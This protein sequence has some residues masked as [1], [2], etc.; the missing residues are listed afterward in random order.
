MSWSDVLDPSPAHPGANDEWHRF[1]HNIAGEGTAARRAWRGR[2][3]RRAAVLDILCASVAGVIGYF[4]WFVWSGLESAPRPPFWFVGLL[5]L[6]WAPAMVVARTYEERFLWVGVE[7]YRRVLSAAVVLLAGVGTVAWA[8]R[9][10]LARGLVVVTLPLTTLLTLL[11]RFAHRHWLSRQR[12]R[13]HYQQTTILV[14]H[15]AAVRALDEQLQREAHQG[16]RVIGCCL[17]RGEHSREADAFDRLPILGALDEVADVVTRVEVDT[18]AVLPS[19][20]LDG[21]FLR[22]LGWQLEDTSAELLVAPAVTEVVGPRVHIRPM[23]GLPLLHMDRPEL[24]GVRRLTKGLFDRTAALLGLVLL[25]P[26][27]W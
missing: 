8:F 21:P 7:E 13:G 23:A 20:E 15:C 17:P 1:A 25:S 19:K 26:S 3:V 16:Y 27:W 11:Q 9:I 18:V 12:R 10:D 4:F 2:Y 5:P 24:T 14:G 22:R 6:V